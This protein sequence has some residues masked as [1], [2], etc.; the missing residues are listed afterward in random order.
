MKKV[1]AICIYRDN[2]IYNLTACHNGNHIVLVD[3]K[4]FDKYQ[5]Y[6]HI[7]FNFLYADVLTILK[8]NGFYCGKV[9]DFGVDWYDI[10]FINLD[11]PTTTN[12]LSYR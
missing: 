12:K 11:E 2:K 4:L 1:T 9:H 7:D 6:K 10:V 3:Y 5:P 8:T